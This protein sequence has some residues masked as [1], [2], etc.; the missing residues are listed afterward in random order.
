MLQPGCAAVLV[1]Y[2]DPASRLPFLALLDWRVAVFAITKQVWMCSMCRHK[3]GVN[4]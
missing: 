4:V 2:G 3:A 1:T